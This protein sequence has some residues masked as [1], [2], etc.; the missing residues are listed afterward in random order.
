MR[1]PAASV[2]PRRAGRAAAAVAGR[3]NNGQSSVKCGSGWAGAVRGGRWRHGVNSAVITADM[4]GGW[5]GGAGP[6]PPPLR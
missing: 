5:A 4:C 3:V 1:G 6:A 2:A